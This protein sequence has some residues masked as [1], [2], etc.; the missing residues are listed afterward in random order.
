V[1]SK[2]L[3][4]LHDETCKLCKDI[5]RTKNSDY[6]G[7]KDATDP[8]ANFKCSEVIGIHPVHGLLMRVLDKVQR[9]RSFV[10]DNELQV[11][12]ESVE[13]ACHDIINYAILA[14]AMLMEERTS[15]GGE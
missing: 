7:G 5:M 10:N 11:P 4:T 13:D 3:L 15:Q 8:F 1:N 9:V 14:K 12:D 6:T 2:E